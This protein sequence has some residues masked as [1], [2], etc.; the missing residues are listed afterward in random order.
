MSVFSAV[1]SNKEMD[2][3]AELQHFNGIFARELLQSK[4]TY[5]PG[6][7]IDILCLIL[8]LFFSVVVVFG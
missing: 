6:T 2:Q 1:C 7:L 5:Q 8:L 4:T 3:S